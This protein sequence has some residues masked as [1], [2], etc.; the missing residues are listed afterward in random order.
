MNIRTTVTQCHWEGVSLLILP[1][2]C[3]AFLSQA[4]GDRLLHLTLGLH[5][6]S[7]HRGFQKTHSTSFS[8]LVQAVASSLALADGSALGWHPVGT[9][10]QVYR[11]GT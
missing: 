1:G 4:F 5:P 10:P 3:G 8:S 2:A 6:L 7:Y 11:G 9:A